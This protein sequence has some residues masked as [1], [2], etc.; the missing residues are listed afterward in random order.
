MPELIEREPVEDYRLTKEQRAFFKSTEKINKIQKMVREGLSFQVG[1]LQNLQQIAQVI[2][3]QKKEL[4]LRAP[5]QSVLDVEDE[6]M[7]EDLR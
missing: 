7:T 3:G 6:G 2:E 5:D 1:K 4:L